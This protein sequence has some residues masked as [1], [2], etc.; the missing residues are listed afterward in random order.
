[1]DQLQPLKPPQQQWR[2]RQR[3]PPL[4]RGSS[5]RR[6][7][8]RRSRASPAKHFAR[9]QQLDDQR[10]AIQVQTQRAAGPEII[11]PTRPTGSQRR[12]RLGVGRSRRW[13]P[14]RDWALAAALDGGDGSVRSTHPPRSET[15]WTTRCSLLFTSDRAA[16]PSP[17]QG[18]RGLFAQLPTPRNGD[19]L[20]VGAS[21]NSDRR[22]WHDSC[23]RRRASESLCPGCLVS[24]APIDA[25]SRVTVLSILRTTRA[26][27]TVIDGGSLQ[28]C[29]MS[30][31][32]CRNRPAD[33]RRGHAGTG[34][35]RQRAYRGSI[36]PVRRGFR[37][38]PYCPP[39]V[40]VPPRPGGRTY[41]SGNRL[42]AATRR[43]R[44][45]KRPVGDA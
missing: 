24:R 25:T 1:M 3:D 44:A 31:R 28:T 39:E 8:G 11:A 15:T 36:R 42:S 33:H 34:P 45:V 12:P 30:Y 32:S 10:L 13:A 2:Q 14:R 18:R 37:F 6:G 26:E 22:T 38:Q 5:S 40:L 20:V 41:P 43:W 21:A 27:M 35:R 19:L 16:T 23:F 9:I 29:P 7:G 17:T 4:P